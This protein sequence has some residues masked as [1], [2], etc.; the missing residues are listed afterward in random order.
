MN[1][2]PRDGASMQALC[3]GGQN[4]IELACYSQ[5]ILVFK[6]LKNVVELGEPLQATIFD[7]G[8]TGNACRTG[9]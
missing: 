2:S 7:S 5:A 4:G 8:K 9:R 6:R 3:R 1:F